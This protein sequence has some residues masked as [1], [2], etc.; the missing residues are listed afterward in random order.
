MS[1]PQFWG[2]DA[3]SVGAYKENQVSEI[4]RPAGFE[5]LFFGLAA[6]KRVLMGES[7]TVPAYQNLDFPTTTVLQE[8]QPIP[9][10]KLSVTAKTISMSERGRAVAITGKTERRSPFDI[11][12]AHRDAVA[13]MMTRELEE[14]ISTAAK[15]TDIKVVLTGAAAES[16]TTNGTA[17]GTAN[18]NPNIYHMQ[19]LGL[20]MSDS[21]RIPVDPRYGA[22]VS[23]FRGAGIYGLQRDSEWREYYRGDKLGSIETQRAGQIGDIVIFK[24]NDPR[25]LLNNIGTGSAFTEGLLMGK[26]SVL[27]GFLDQIGLQYDFSKTKATDFGRFKYIAWLGDYGAGLFSDSVDAGLARTLHVTTA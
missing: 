15:L 8:D 24:H 13:V 7:L 16:I 18:S 22:Y 10:S 9:M 26:D 23:V 1:S 2:A 11:L 6:K 25:V 14:V 20:Y 12:Q 17:S 4:F 21:L 19:T 3:P 27:F 5:S